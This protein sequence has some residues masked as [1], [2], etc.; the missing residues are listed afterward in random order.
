MKIRTLQSKDYERWDEYTF[1]HPD[2]TFFHLSGWKKVIEAS[3][4]HTSYYLIAEHDGMI[5]GIFPLFHVKSFLFGSSLVSIPVIIC[6]GICADDTEVHSA[7]LDEG[8]KLAKRLNVKYLE[9]KNTKKNDGEDNKDLHTKDLYFNFKKTISKD[10][11]ENLDA[12]PRKQRRMIKVSQ[13]NDFQST[14]GR[15]H[16]AEFYNIF[17]GSYRDLGTPVF[18]LNYLRNIMDIFDESCKILS[19]WHDNRMVAAVMT[20]FFKETVIPYYSGAV[21]EYYKRAVSDYMYWELMKYSC[22]NGY[23]V[24][25]FGRSKKGTGP[26]NFKRHWG[27]EPEPLPYQYYLVRDKEVPNLNPTNPKFSTFISIWK[28][29]PVPITKILGPQIVKLIP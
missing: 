10:L 24:F 5:K 1:N 22:E 18:S 14:I 8:K 9:M 13:K 15:D 23:R 25:D 7:L 26:Y 11:K 28:K 3:F 2:S 29:L 27:F 19:V 21:K 16:L 17:A 20:F 6:G 4:K 12:I